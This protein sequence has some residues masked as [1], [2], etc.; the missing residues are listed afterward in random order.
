MSESKAEQKRRWAQTPAGKASIAADNKK[1]HQRKLELARAARAACDRCG[2]P[3]GTGTGYGE[4]SG[5]CQQCRFDV[6]HEERHERRKT[7]EKLWLQGKTLKEIAA[8]LGSSA[9]AVGV[10]MSEMRAEGGWRLPYRQ[11]PT[12]RT[13]ST[14]TAHRNREG[15]KHADER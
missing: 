1:R 9:N 6:Q 2:K 8:E 12:R 11:R 13:R 4:H 10:A 15:R 5:L 14:P 3:R 7:I